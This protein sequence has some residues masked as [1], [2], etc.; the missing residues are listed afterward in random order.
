MNVY[1]INPNIII[2]NDS[3][4]NIM[5]NLTNDISNNISVNTNIIIENQ[6]LK[7]VNIIFNTII[8]Y[9]KIYKFSVFNIHNI[10]VEIYNK[11]INTVIYEYFTITNYYYFFTNSKW[12]NFFKGLIYNP[13]IVYDNLNIEEKKK[14]NYSIV[15]GELYFLDNITFN[16]NLNQ[17]T[18]ILLK[19]L[20]SCNC[21][22]PRPCL[23][24]NDILIISL[25]WY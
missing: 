21:P 15:N 8:K 14:L 9:L 1:N 23:C 11:N 19:K 5:L 3:I 22:C 2:T 12:I 20:C 7:V 25:Y 16:Y 13:S 17:A 4:S 18:G 24:L 6:Y 10:C